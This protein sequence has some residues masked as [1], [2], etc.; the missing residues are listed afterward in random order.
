[1]YLSRGASSARPARAP[2][3]GRSRRRSVVGGACAVASLRAIPWAS[4]PSTRLGRRAAD[5]RRERRRD[6]L[7]A[8]SAASGQGVGPRVFSLARSRRDLCADRRGDG[9]EV[10]RGAATRSRASRRRG[11][12]GPEP[13]VDEDLE[14]RAPPPIGADCGCCVGARDGRCAV[15]RG[16]AAAAAAGSARARRRAPRRPPASRSAFLRVPRPSRGPSCR[17]PRRS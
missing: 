10:K 14:G 3:R 9:V 2:A 1:M 11:R 7:G 5:R 16:A 8:G 12:H 4:T 6:V 17:A 13:L 15:S